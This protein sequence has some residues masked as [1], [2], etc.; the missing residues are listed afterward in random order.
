MKWYKIDET[1]SNDEY[2]YI[3]LIGIG[4]V[5]IQK[6]DEGIIVDMW[7]IKPQDK[8]TGMMCATYNDL[9]P[10]EE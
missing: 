1:S 6:D 8:P 9:N 2:L 5:C 4:S 10:K 7:G 3:D